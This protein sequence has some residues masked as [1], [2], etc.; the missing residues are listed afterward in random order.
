M[1]LLPGRFARQP[2]TVWLRRALFQVHLWTGIG[3]GL[4]VL[5]VSLSGSAIVFRRETDKALC[6]RH[7]TV[8]P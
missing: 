4:Y 6:P 3:A 7:V 5:L 1:R 8:T 2:Q